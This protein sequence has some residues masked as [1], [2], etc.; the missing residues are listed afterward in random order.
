MQ[1]NRNDDFICNSYRIHL[2]YVNKFLVIVLR[3]FRPCLVIV[4]DYVLSLYIVL[5]I[6]SNFLYVFEDVLLLLCMFVTIFCH[7]FRYELQQKGELKAED[8]GVVPDIYMRNQ[9][10]DQEIK[11][12]HKEVVRFREAAM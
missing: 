6:F 7:C 11:L 10:L 8:V 12:L 5:G 1:L 3:Y 4:F 2:F 9:Q